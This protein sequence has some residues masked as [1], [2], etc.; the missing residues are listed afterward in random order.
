MTPDHFEAS[1]VVSLDR[2]TVWKRLTEH[3]IDAADGSERYWLPGFDSAATVTEEDAGKR[4]RLTKDDATS[5]GLRL[6]GVRRDSLAQRLG[7]H[8]DDLLVV[9]AGAPV[10]NHDDLVTVL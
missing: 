9:L 8:D 10:S 2:D 3:P 4:L 5:G 6:S 7:L 1:F